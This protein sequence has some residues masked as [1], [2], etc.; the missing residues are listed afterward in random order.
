LAGRGL[1]FVVI[2]SDPFIF[3]RARGAGWPAVFGDATR[4]DVLEQAGIAEARICA[5]TFSSPADALLTSQAARQLN[6]R[7][8]V[9]ARSTGDG[10]ALLRRAGATEVVDPDFESS[11]EFVRH[12]LHRFGIDA[13]EIGA[14]QSRWRADHYRLPE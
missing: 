11:L 3:E 6:P 12:A 9:I 13:R 10:I 5:I 8:D 4:A 1:P 14:I 7:I 2:E